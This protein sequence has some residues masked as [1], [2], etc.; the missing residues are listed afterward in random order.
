[1][2]EEEEEADIQTVKCID[3]YNYKLQM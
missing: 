3:I 1:M 2:Q